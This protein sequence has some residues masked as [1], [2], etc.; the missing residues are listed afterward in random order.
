MGLSQSTLAWLCF[1]A[2]LLGIGL[3]ILYDVLRITRIFLGVHYRPRLAKR[4]RSKALPL[5]R[6]PAHRRES[7]ALGFVVFLED[8]FFCLFAGVAMIL[9]FYEINNGKIR[10]PAF[11]CAGCGFLL[12][13]ATLCR[14]ILPMLETIAFVLECSVRYLWFF[15]SYP[16]RVAVRVCAGVAKKCIAHSRAAGQK[17]DRRRYTERERERG[18]RNACGLIPEET[19]QKRKMRRGQRIVKQQKTNQSDAVDARAA[20]GAGAHLDRHFRQ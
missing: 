15:A 20:G 17:R 12:Y 16:V 2:W 3:G 4:L 19:E 8:L 11:L 13:R 18:I 7:R 9:L 1:Y 5:I 6:L 14:F 10:Y